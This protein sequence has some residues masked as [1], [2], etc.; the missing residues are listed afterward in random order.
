MRRRMTARSKK[1]TRFYH[2]D[3]CLAES[4]L[5]DLASSTSAPRT[6]AGATAKVQQPEVVKKDLQTSEVSR[7]PPYRGTSLIRNTLL[8]GPYSRTIPWVLWWF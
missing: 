7:A 3:V 5:V 4:V 2:V 6:Y 1:K 8:L